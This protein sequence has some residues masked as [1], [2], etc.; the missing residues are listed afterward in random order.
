MVIRA[1]CCEQG[2]RQVFY[3]RDGWVVG[4][5]NDL[6]LAHAWGSPQDFLVP[7]KVRFCP[8]CGWDL[9]VNPNEP[10]ADALERVLCSPDC[11]P[12]RLCFDVDG[13]LCDDRGTDGHWS[14]PTERPYAGRKPYP[15]ASPLLK[16]LRAHGHTVVVQT[17]RYM[18]KF[19]GDQEKVRTYGLMELK[20]WLNEHDIPYDEVYMGKASANLYIDDRGCRVE[21]NAGTTE[22]GRRFLPVLSET[23]R[24]RWKA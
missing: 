10:F 7:V 19:D 17:A 15:W 20:N 5:P 6:D 22:W 1:E 23:L 16:K 14:S 13:V 3:H 9:S 4:I 12:K 21:S 18:N 8:F 2:R 11:E 24:K